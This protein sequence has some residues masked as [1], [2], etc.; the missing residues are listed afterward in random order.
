MEHEFSKAWKEGVYQAIARRRDMRHFL[1]D[2]IPT[3]TLA[4]ILSA[5]HH[6]ASVGYMQPWNFVV[7]RD[8]AKRNEIKA[9]VD[10]ERLIA[11]EH[12][13]KERKEKYLS[14]KLEGIVESPLN[15]CITCDPTRAG[16]VVLGRNTIRETDIYSTCCAIQNLWLAARAEGIGV[17]WVSILKTDVLRKILAMPDHILPI[18]YLC[19]GYVAAFPARPMLETSG[20][21]PRM[22]L[23][24][25]VYGD[26]WGQPVATEF[27]KALRECRDLEM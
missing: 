4:R 3:E 13:E 18:G 27:S 10:A 14:F 23:E 8:L 12:F 2:P 25:L 1:P 26:Q 20:W 17:G 15:I 22:P 7:I 21:L 16:P 5:A 6:A 11:A 24:E 19:M 9:H